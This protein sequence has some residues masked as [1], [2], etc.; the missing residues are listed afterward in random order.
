MNK[1]IENFTLKLSR[2]MAAC[3]FAI[4]SLLPASS[5][6]HNVGQVQ[7]TIYFAPETTA[8]LASRAASSAG[9]AVGFVAGDVISYIISFQ[10]VPNPAWINNCVGGAYASTGVNGYITDYIPANTQVV[11]ASFVQ[12]DG[13]TLSTPNAPGPMVEGAVNVFTAP[14][15]G[16]TAGAL[17]DL[18]ADT[19][20][21]YS[22]D[23]RTALDPTTVGT[24]NIAK[25]G[26]PG[27][28]VA[29]LRGACLATLI[30]PAIITMATHNLWDADQTNAFGSA[31]APVTAP[32]SNVLPSQT[33][34]GTT[35]L[36]AGSPVAG[37]DSGFK[38]DNTTF[39]G[40]WQRIYAPGSTIGCAAGCATT[41]G[42][43]V[44]VTR[45]TPTSQ[46][47]NVSL[48]NPLPSNVNAVR[49][50][51]GQLI[52]GQPRYVKI[53]VKLLAN[54]P[55]T[56]L[57]NSAEV[58]GG[59]SDGSTSRD[60]P[61]VYWV[62]SS[63]NN[64]SNLFIQKTIT[65]VC[66]F[67]QN[68]ALTVGQSAAN[69]PA[70]TGGNIPPN[71]TLRYQITYTNLSNSTQHQV[72]LSDLLPV[73]TG[74]PPAAT[75]ATLAQLPTLVKNFS[76]TGYNLSSAA[77]AYP[78][79]TVGT[80]TTSPVVS[81][82][83]ISSLGP[84]M[85]GTVAFDV[86][87]S[88]PTSSPT[89][90]VMVSNTA[91]IT[92]F[93]IP[94]GATASASASVVTAPAADVVITKTALSSNVSPG[95]TASY[96]I[97]LTNVGSGP[98]VITNIVDTLP[99]FG[100][101]TAVPAT[102]ALTRMA[103]VVGS[104]TSVNNGVVGTAPTRTV[105]NPPVATPNK[106]L[107]TFVLNPVA[108]RTLAAGTS[109]TLTF[110]AIVGANMPAAG[111]P[112]S[113]IA[114]TTYT[115]GALGTIMPVFT[116]APVT[117]GAGLTVN[118]VVDCVY[119]VAAICQPYIGAALLANAKVRYKISYANTSTQAM[120]NVYI[121]DEIASTQTAPL[122]NLSTVNNA[123]IA[124]TP[125][126]SGGLSITPTLPVIPAPAA[127]AACGF[128]AAASNKI[129]FNYPVINPLDA[130][131]SGIVYYE[132]TTNVPINAAATAVSLTNTAKIISSATVTGP[133]AA[134]ASAATSTPVQATG[135]KLV[136]SKSVA[137]PIGNAVGHA[138]G[139]D[140][141]NY[142]ITVTN[143]GNTATG[144][145]TAANPLRVVD[146]LPGSGAANSLPLRFTYLPAPVAPGAAPS[147]TIGAG[148]ATAFATA[149]TVVVTAATN[150][151][152]VTFTLPVGTIIP[153]GGTFTISF[154]AQ[155]G[156]AMPALATSYNNS[157]RASYLNGATVTTTPIL[158][159]AAPVLV[160]P[161]LQAT[162]TIDCIYD[163]LGVCQ[164]YVAGAPLPVNYT[165]ATTTKIRYRIDY[166]NNATAAIPFVFICDQMSSTQG[167]TF[168]APVTA[169]LA[170]AT[171][172]P[173]PNGPSAATFN[174]PAVAACGYGAAV[175][176]QVRF[177]FATITSLAAKATGIVYFDAATNI[178]SGA[179]LTNNAKL[180]SATLATGTVASTTVLPSAV[181]TAA[182]TAGTAN[183]VVSKTVD[184]PASY[185]G[186]AVRYTISVTN[187]GLAP[188]TMGT[189]VDTLPGSGTGNVV[190][191]RFA[192]TALPAPAAS[193][194]GVATAVPTA[195]VTAPAAAPALNN[196][197]VT[198]TIAPAVVIAPGT[199]LTLSFTATVGL[200]VT[201]SATA[202]TNDAL[203]NYT[204]GAAGVLNGSVLGA[205]PVTVGNNPLT[206]NKSI[207]CVYDTTLP[208]PICQ[209]YVAG[210][211]L[212]LNAKIRYRIDYANT[213]AAP[214]A[215]V[216]LCD[217][218]SS[219]QAAPL[220]NLT[221]IANA[222]IANTSVLS[223]GVPVTPALPAAPAAAVA[224]CGFGV[225]ATSAKSFNYAVINP[226]DGNQAGTVYYEATTN[227]V[228]SATVNNLISITTSTLPTALP[229]TSNS[230]GVSATV[231]P[232][233]V[234]TANLVVSKAVVVP[235]GNAAGQAF[236][237]NTVTYT[238]T[239]QNTGAA[240][241]VVTTIVDTLPGVGLSNVV[242]SRFSYVLASVTGLNNGVAIAAPTAVVTVP[243]RNR[244]NNEI[245]TFTLPAATSI[246][247]GTSLTLT[248]NVLVGAS[249]LPSPSPYT[250]TAM[251]NYTGGPVGVLAAT[252]TGAPVTV[253]SPLVATKT[254]DCVYDAANI[255]QPYTGTGTIPANAVST[256]VRYKVVYNNISVA[257]V[258]NVYVCDQLTSTQVA[259]V[260]TA[261]ITAPAAPV[262]TLV[263]PAAPAAAVAA[264]G[265]LPG[266]VTFNYPVIASLAVNTPG[267]LYY[268]ALTNVANGSILNNTV[269]LV[270]SATV[271][272]P[273]T[274]TSTP[275]TVSSYAVNVP[276]LNIGKATSTPTISP[277]GS[278]TY[279]ITI[280]NT[281]NAPT[282]SLKVYDFLPFNGTLLDATQRF[283]YQ[284]TTTYTKSTTLLPT[285]AAFVPSAPFTITPV[286]API[287][288]PYSVNTNQQQ[289]TWD[290]GSAPANQLAPGDTLT[291]TFTATAGSAMPL[292]SYNNSVGFE[293]TSS[294]GPGSNSLNGLA[295][296][297]LAPMLT[298]NKKIIAVCSGVGCTPT[299]YT[300]GALLPPNALIRY[301]I[302]YTNPDPLNAHT[303]V[304]LSDVLP[305]QTGV[306]SVSNVVIS[307]GAITAPSAA[308][309]SALAG[310]G[311]TLT[312][313][314]LAT[315][316]ANATGSIT[317]DVQT[318]ATA[319][320]A[321]NNTA[322]LLSTQLSTPI[323]STA[324][325]TV[326]DLEVIKTIVGVCGG[327]ACTPTAYTPGALIPV[328]AKIRYQLA[329]RNASA[330][331]AQ[332]NV[333]LR[334][335]LPSQT[336]AA[337]VSNVVIVNGAITAP[338]AATLSALG[339]GGATLTF[340][341]LATLPVNATGTITLDVQT[342]AP[343]ASKVSNTA[344]LLSNQDAIGVSSTVTAST[345]NL[346]LSK[347]LIGVCAGAAC[348]P[349]AYTPGAVIPPNAKLRY[350]ISYSNASTV[351]AQT[352]V[353]LSDVLP[354][355]TAAASVS[356]V[357]IVS[358]SITAP[359]AATLSGL[360]AGGATLSFPTLASLAA[361]TGG[362][363]T[364]DVQTNAA[365]GVT[366]SN[367]AKLVSSEDT[368]GQSS[369]AS[370]EVTNLL[371]SKTT[372]TA[373]TLQGGVA[374]YTI[375]ITNASAVS[376]DTLQVYDFL[377]FNGTVVD[378]TQQFTL[379]VG[380]SA[381]T[382]GLPA[383]TVPTTAVAPT[384]A[385]YS[386][387]TNQQEVLWDFGTFV[388]GAGASASI[389]FNAAVGSAM[390]LG[391]YANSATVNYKVGGV[392]K[393]SSI[394][395]TANVQLV[396]KPT[397][398][399]SKVVK[400]FSDPV[401]GTTNPKFLPGGV[402]EYT[403]TASN[404]GG[405]ADGVIIEDF[406][407][408][409]TT[410]YVRDLATVG[411]GPVMFTPG[412]SG[413]S[414]Q[415]LGLSSMV[416]DLEFFNGT[417][418]T[419]VPAPG[420][421]GCD[422][423][424]TKIRVK[425]T[426]TFAGNITTP[427]SFTVSFRVCVQ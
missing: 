155:V 311:A 360:A 54:P 64:N 171:N 93:E 233:P 215:N 372:S 111:S 106:E 247:A 186:D 350:Q 259:P 191:A 246:A 37:P 104:A 407:P 165:T 193:N 77:P 181:S 348:T 422:P 58:S 244:A 113:N 114:T 229:T 245:V 61:W 315:L 416:D 404:A 124:N 282:T 262:S 296:V 202:Y 269:K 216:Y 256:K 208:T 292:T 227:A 351:A 344:R 135:A 179:T 382:G 68:A 331:I 182:A 86:S 204:G 173:A 152:A 398:N 22:S 29:P 417:V 72:A 352:N 118:K 67:A 80:A 268:D 297:T 5:F 66:T 345:P 187:T 309:L 366:V 293:F 305:T 391:N 133:A 370:A 389:S 381:Y 183:L 271:A 2:G 188:A 14:F 283:N 284:A 137:V 249:I 49:W 57:L 363:I 151:E 122:F 279:T 78:A 376:A 253:D 192:Y 85:G 53:S 6:A 131:Q 298:V 42:T 239:M 47:V 45:T 102:D 48:A 332:T 163:S 419:T 275:S 335:I 20:I 286:V 307:S 166:A 399:L 274:V 418:W 267:T 157:A 310:G 24:G 141:V 303:N 143:T 329:Y 89:A 129:N 354:A 343:V 300:P 285:P 374:T 373:Q 400:A 39:L 368:T 150:S 327:A 214:I 357:I 40:P 138:Y 172:T 405:A 273:A 18:Y 200:N 82:A 401:D 290:F 367:T 324:S 221:T 378:A 313:P 115:G 15:V 387:N 240:P 218:I 87:L 402:A 388:L 427:P 392:A 56:G 8:L 358:G 230:G 83:P 92:T 302:D 97:T 242:A 91:K 142:T 21:F 210:A 55:V 410:L 100:N 336:A 44:P 99:G 264:C 175:A 355:Q 277:S 280:S 304:V 199:T 278:A 109:L 301:Q 337:A 371:I 126:L 71:A 252:T 46:G 325:A 294:G 75:P 383:A 194:N 28:Y 108:Q 132:A 397:I 319:G 341:T 231:V 362:V 425:P 396:A 353:V 176:G 276:E 107:N 289:V 412:L 393:S 38:L 403:V 318:N 1:S 258:T 167:A 385:P 270:S 266:G 27:Y 84:A 328:N 219:S 257:P 161:A 211:Q 197:I 17:P 65:N 88:T 144:A 340:P 94:A 415:Y 364:L 377:P 116:G 139:G 134:M 25:Q 74:V 322:K 222:P 52:V 261:T 136:V 178:A 224:A 333:V 147:Y 349:T 235:V 320:M 51:A 203:V 43:A 177:N 321:V 207:D 10:P 406:V 306:A 323:S 117:V 62:A 326:T 346:L 299:A 255:C 288:T 359:N 103:F 248:F 365:A 338:A 16:Y 263:L 19:G 243:R 190:A 413:L 254:I 212:P 226:L 59:D 295:P 34:G 90:P 308:T 334:D 421:D 375:T 23:P 11:G 146:T 125:V 96:S 206:V 386:A 390:P 281:G 361:N 31:A 128:A 32:K 426:G 420:A 234:T 241:A 189:I 145:S 195:V 260:F 237:G 158:V 196:E 424:I 9:G 164:P 291:I 60:N 423:T 411:S 287:V 73:E 209:P 121:C 3:V 79:Y 225:V 316:P 50:A 123:P 213:S 120:N 12:A 409:N 223:G 95:G 342:N 380:S 184:K 110:N 63:A 314:T 35:P 7:T 36:N 162:K 339:A 153:A 414:Y 347:T 205:A 330:T 70:Y 168:T 379:V 272:G 217:K 180:V 265:F 312:F 185:G 105:T 169:S 4:A 228:N 198:F 394:D 26:Q 98:A 81:F 30:D 201:P 127:I 156:A 317:L 408:A 33:A 170:P 232:A 356:N 369:T 69:C 159:G 149:P 41:L 220:F 101:S 13:T 154:T 238:I 119:D 160:D 130:G 251:V 236:A 76:Y 112:Y 250:N 395:A 174:N 148:L 140:L 384:L